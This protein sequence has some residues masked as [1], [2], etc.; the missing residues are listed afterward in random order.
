MPRK[1][2]SVRR[3][4]SRSSRRKSRSSTRRRYRAAS[5]PVLE[6]TERQLFQAHTTHVPQETIKV[7]GNCDEKR[8]TTIPRI[9]S[10]L[11]KAEIK[12]VKSQNGVNRLLNS[13][14]KAMS[15]YDSL[16]PLPEGWMSAFHE[17]SGLYYYFQI[18]DGIP[19]PAQWKHPSSSEQDFFD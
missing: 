15:Q 5:C 10:S 6:A 1:P 2:R 4:R 18:I 12:N 8:D 13:A 3:R 9:I 17:D 16:K 14:T 11:K 7:G 19:Q